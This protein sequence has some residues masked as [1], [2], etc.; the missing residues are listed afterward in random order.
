V[1]LEYKLLVNGS[2]HSLN[3]NICDVDAVGIGAINKELRS[4][5]LTIDSFNLVQL[6]LDDNPAKLVH[7]SYCRIPS[8]AGLP[9]NELYAPDKSPDKFANSYLLGFSS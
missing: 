5:Y 2:K 7:I 4:P 1:R 9:I 6:Y 8:D 3:P